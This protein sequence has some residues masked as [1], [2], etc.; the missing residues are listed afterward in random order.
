MSL[1]AIII[2][3]NQPWLL[4]E[5]AVLVETHI[6]ITTQTHTDTYVASA[7]MVFH[8]DSEGLAGIELHSLRCS[9]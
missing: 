6:R 4:W 2:P 1:F 3:K 7:Y 8:A 9:G 5:R